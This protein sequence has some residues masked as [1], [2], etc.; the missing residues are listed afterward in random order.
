MVKMGQGLRLEFEAETQPGINGPAVIAF[1]TQFQGLCCRLSPWRAGA[2]PSH[3]VYRA[4]H[5]GNRVWVVWA[6]SCFSPS[7]TFPPQSF[8]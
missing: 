5:M 3:L 7:L 8:L 4:W 6:S 1:P 2:V